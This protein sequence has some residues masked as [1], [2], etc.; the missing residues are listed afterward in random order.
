MKK[1]T[2]K[3]SIIILLVVGCVLSILVQLGYIT[4]DSAD[5][6][7]TSLNEVKNCVELEDINY[8]E[9]VNRGIELGQIS[10]E[11]GAEILDHIET[12]NTSMENSVE[13]NKQVADF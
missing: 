8:G 4:Q 10:T 2:Q 11:L 1:G 7:E 5:K 12:E 9:C 13:L 3:I 6:F